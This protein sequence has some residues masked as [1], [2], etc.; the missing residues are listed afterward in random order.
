MLALNLLIT[1]LYFIFFYWLVKKLF[2]VWTTQYYFSY[3]LNRPTFTCYICLFKWLCKNVHHIKL[4]LFTINWTEARISRQM[5]ACLFQRAY[6]NGDCNRFS[7]IKLSTRSQQQHR[8]NCSCRTVLKFFT[9]ED[10]VL[11]YT[12][13]NPVSFICRW[14]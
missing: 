8:N 6:Q 13:Q 2:S 10:Q 12:L 14:P 7:F 11:K 5:V 3:T 1:C 4:R 9:W